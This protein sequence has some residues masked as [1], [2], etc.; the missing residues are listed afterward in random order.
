MANVNSLFKVPLSTC[1]Q[2]FIVN[3]FSI[4]GQLATEGCNV[5]HYSTCYQNLLPS[6]AHATKTCCPQ[7]HMRP[8]LGSKFYGIRRFDPYAGGVSNLH[9]SKMSITWQGDAGQLRL[10]LCQFEQYCFMK[11]I[12]KEQDILQCSLWPICFNQIAK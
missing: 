5:A 3:L 9:P 11:E 6:V 4:Q 8:K 2:S 12:L 10:N 7:Q 1:K